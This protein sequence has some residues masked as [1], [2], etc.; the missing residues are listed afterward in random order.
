MDEARLVL[1]YLRVLVWP[2]VV[3]GAVLIFRHELRDVARRLTALE[4]FG[5]KAAL[6]ESVRDAQRL[7]GSASQSRAPKE[8]PS[9]TTSF[10]PKSYVEARELAETFRSGE[11]VLVSLEQAPDHDAK[12]LI[13]FM[14]GIVFQSRGHIE[15]VSSKVFLI[16]PGGQAKRGA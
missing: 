6:K 4:G 12:R 10:K 3:T 1:D 16:T 5:V 7:T 14:A 15:R 13:D 2:L 8:I 11:A 9:G